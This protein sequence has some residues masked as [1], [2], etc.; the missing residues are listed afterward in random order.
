MQFMYP[1]PGLG[2]HWHRQ[3]RVI[4]G[5][6]IELIG[7]WYIELVQNVSKDVRARNA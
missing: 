4:D 2:G 3:V 6:Y 5:W 1:S 7:G